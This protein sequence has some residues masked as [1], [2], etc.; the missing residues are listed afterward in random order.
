MP[1]SIKKSLADKF[2]SNYKINNKALIIKKSWDE[3]HKLVNTDKGK[4]KG[5]G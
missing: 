5:K 4:K 2:S 1:S 3:V